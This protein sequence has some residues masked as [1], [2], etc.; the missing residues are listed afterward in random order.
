MDPGGPTVTLKAAGIASIAR[1]SAD[2]PEEITR[3]VVALISQ[4]GAESYRNREAATKEL[5]K[6]GKGIVPL[7]KKHAKSPDPEVRQRIEDILRQLEA[8]KVERG[9]P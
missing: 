8:K 9:A 7:L 2:P 1:P 3:K 4:L 6:M 5:V